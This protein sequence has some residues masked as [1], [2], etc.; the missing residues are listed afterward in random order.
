MSLL[1]YTTPS[2]RV[3]MKSSHSN[4]TSSRIFHRCIPTK[5]PPSS[6]RDGDRR[7]R[8]RSWKSGECHRGRR[9]WSHP[10]G[11][12]GWPPPRRAARRRPSWWHPPIPMPFPKTKKAGWQ[13][14][15]R[16]ATS[17]LRRE[18]FGASPRWLRL[19]VRHDGRRDCRT[20]VAHRDVRCCRRPVSS[21]G[22]GTR[23]Q[24]RDMRRCRPLPRGGFDTRRR[25]GRRTVGNEGWIIV[26]IVFLRVLRRPFGV[27][28]KRCFNFDHLRC[29]CTRWI[30]PD[31]LSSYSTSFQ[32][33]ELIR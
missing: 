2:P 4:N 27:V 10:T 11:P 31:N 21:E 22:F 24:R 15:R 7:S 23:G 3:M 8:S 13:H 26:L 14:E 6:L 12:S 29:G 28:R 1:D 25:R 33:S 20:F 17:T 18:G 30:C 16:R 5:P 9:R 19:V 32:H